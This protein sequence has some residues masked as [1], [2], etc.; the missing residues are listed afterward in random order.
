MKKVYK[1]PQVK[2][3]TL[4]AGEYLSPQAFYAALT[5]VFT[6]LCIAAASLGALGLFDFIHVATT[7]STFPLFFTTFGGAMAAIFATSSAI[8]TKRANKQL[9]TKY[10]LDLSYRKQRTVTQDD[11]S[12]HILTQGFERRMDLLPTLSKKQKIEC[13]LPGQWCTHKEEEVMQIIAKFD[14]ENDLGFRKLCSVSLKLFPLTDQPTKNI[15]YDSKNE[16][17]YVYK[18]GKLMTFS[19]AMASHYLM[20]KMWIFCDQQ[21]KELSA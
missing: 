16:S 10:L 7:P 5:L 1:Q 21:I 19:G 8:F 20:Q 11:L 4:P 3:R 9:E 6:A 12:L 17:L 15:L 2:V 18:E 13:L 14:Y